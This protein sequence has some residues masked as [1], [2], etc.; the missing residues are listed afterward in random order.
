MNITFDCLNGHFGIPFFC[1]L[2]CFKVCNVCKFSRLKLS[3]GSH[4]SVHHSFRIISE[5]LS[6][7]FDWNCVVT[8]TVLNLSY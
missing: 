4:T 5:S 3:H 2:Q 1:F 8:L 7:V 6:S